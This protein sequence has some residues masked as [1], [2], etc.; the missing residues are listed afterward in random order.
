[1][2]DSEASPSSKLNKGVVHMFKKK[3]STVLLA[4]LCTLTIAAALPNPPQPKPE[5]VPQIT[6]E[7]PETPEIMPLKGKDDTDI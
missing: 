1:M 4:S 2:Q 7:I 6:E 3:I 5:D